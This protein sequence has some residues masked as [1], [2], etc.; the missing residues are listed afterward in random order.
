MAARCPR[1]DALPSYWPAVLDRLRSWRPR[2]ARAGPV[3]LVLARCVP[4]GCWFHVER[5]H[6]R[7]QI[8][9]RRAGDMVSRETAAG[10]AARTRPLTSPNAGD[11]SRETR[12]GVAS[13]N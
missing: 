6:T 3:V 12:Q 7:R 4:A 8:L 10:K 13:I 11:D 9:G 2:C 1:A 5:C